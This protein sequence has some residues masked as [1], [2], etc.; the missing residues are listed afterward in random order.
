MLTSDETGYTFRHALLREVIHDDLLPGQHARL[1]AH[2]AMILE[3]HPELISAASAADGDR[4]SLERG[5]RGEQGIPMGIDRRR[6]G[7]CGF[8]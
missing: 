6:L 4:P 2:F 1:H 8:P 3:E 7:W 5:A